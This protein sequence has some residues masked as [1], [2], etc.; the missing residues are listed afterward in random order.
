MRTLY[1]GRDSNPLCLTQM[2][3]ISDNF[4]PSLVKTLE[5]DQIQRHLATG[6]HKIPRRTYIIYTNQGLVIVPPLTTRSAVVGG[7][8]GYRTRKCWTY[9]CGLEYLTPFG[10]LLTM[11]YTQLPLLK[12]FVVPTRGLEPRTSRLKVGRSDHVP[13]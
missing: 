2:I 3:Q 1:Y 5:I 10:T 13:R 7:C 11:S 8:I 4:F 9:A 6:R 12:D